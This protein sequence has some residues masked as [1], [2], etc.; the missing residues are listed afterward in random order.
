[1][2][3]SLKDY[4]TTKHKGL[5]I[6]KTDLNKFLFN[7][8]LDGKATRQVLN[9]NPAYSKPDKL[10]TAYAKLEELKGVKTRVASSGADIKATVDEYFDR[11]QLMTARNEETQKSYKRHYD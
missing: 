5:L 4:T 1:M 11:L 6:H 7:F 10:K 8:R 2:A 9:A 3:I